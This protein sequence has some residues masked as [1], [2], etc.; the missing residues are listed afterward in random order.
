VRV[1]VTGGSGRLGQFAIAEL[2][3]HGH[4]VVNADRRRG[5]DGG[6]KTRFVETDLSDVGQVA[7]LLKD[8]DAV[9]HLGAIPAPWSHA[10][11]V[12][13]T[14]NTINTYSV[15]QAAWITDIPKVA[16]A[17]S[18]S[19]YGMAWSVA[20]RPP[21]FVPVDETHPFLVAEP[22]GLS[23]EVDERTAE[24][25]HRRSG[26][27]AVGLR[28]HWVANP[29]ELTGVRE[30]GGG[31]PTQHPNNLWGYVDARDA[32]SAIRL[33]IEVDGLGFEAF[34]ITAADTLCAEPTQELIDR[35]FPGI[36]QRAALP[37]HATCFPIEKAERLLG[38]TPRASWRAHPGD[39]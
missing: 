36:D 10:D 19:A 16:F 7:G 14:N 4:E 1:L 22:Y 24:M 6:P 30:R 34:N 23:K 33:A 11:E 12:V 9:V 35:F 18:A 13:F 25:F 38:W 15:F 17:S 31:D 5:P 29:D 26:M 39:G 3:E 28:F 32:A 20:S 8:C 27:Q 2:L 21:L 37:G